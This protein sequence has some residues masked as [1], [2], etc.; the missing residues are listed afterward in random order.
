MCGSLSY[1]WTKKRSMRSIRRG[2]WG[3]W[4][5]PPWLST[6]YIDSIYCFHYVDYKLS[7]YTMV[8]MGKLAYMRGGYVKFS[9]KMCRK[10]QPLVGFNLPLKYKFKDD[11]MVSCYS[12]YNRVC[13]HV[14]FLWENHSQF[15]WNGRFLRS[16]Y[17]VKKGV[18]K[19]IIKSF[20]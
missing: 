14:V 12:P 8:K 7:L 1:G 6:S 9:P 17:M 5:L 13:M 20:G 4:N 3:S 15:A 19:L 10:L 2:I 16:S 11:V 18:L